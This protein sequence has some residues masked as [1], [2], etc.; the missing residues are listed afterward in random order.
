MARD[1]ASTVPD[2]PSALADAVPFS[3]ALVTP[4]R[5]VRRREGMLIG[6]PSGFGEFAPFDDY[7]DWAASRWLGSAIEA[8]F[9]TWPTPRRSQVTS[10]AIIPDAP[11]AETVAM[12]RAAVTTLGCTVLKVKVGGERDVAEDL[13][14]IRA[15]A[16][17]LDAEL[18]GDRGMLRIDVN[19]AWE[20]PTAI[21]ALLAITDAAGGRLDYAEQPCARLDDLALVR[22]RTGVRIAVDEPVRRAV[23]PLDPALIEAVRACADVLIVKA[24]PLGGVH[25]GLDIAAGYGLGVVVSGS[26]DSSVG[27]ASGI[28][29]AA[30]VP[31]DLPSGLGTGALLATDLVPQATL[32]VGGRIAIARRS[33]DPECL[34]RARAAIDPD[35]AQWWRQRLIAAWAAAGRPQRDR[36]LSTIGADRA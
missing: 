31:D 23:D 21:A 12:S 36:W 15:I 7:P 27:L 3:I 34:R 13:A 28:A 8:A 20:A 14:R 5:R 29:L 9:G 16:G 4:F 25:A 10:N 24:A 22:E 11:F 18:G 30:A 17:V 32:P 1:D 33:P 6:G 2:L 35:R 26:L 19:G